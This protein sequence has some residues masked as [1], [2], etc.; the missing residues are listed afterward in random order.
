MLTQADTDGAYGGPLTV[1]V[2]QCRASIAAGHSAQ[3]VAGWVAD[4]PAPAMLDGV[5]AR[6]SAPAR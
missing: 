4:P 5:P 6:L 1:A 3:L 2:A